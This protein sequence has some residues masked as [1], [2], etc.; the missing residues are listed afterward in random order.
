[1]GNATTEMRVTSGLTPLLER[2]RAIHDSRLRYIESSVFMVF[3][4]LN[5]ARGV[6]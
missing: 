5:L 1:M 3:N 2:A 4:F 6:N